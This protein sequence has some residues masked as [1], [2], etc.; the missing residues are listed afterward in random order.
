[1]GRVIKIKKGLTIPMNGMAER[2]MHKLPLPEFVAVKPTDFFG[3][4]PKLLVNEGDV[5]HAGQALVCDKINSKIVL[6]APASGVV[7]AIERGEKRKLEQ[8]VVKTD[9]EIHYKQFAVPELANATR[10]ELID[11]ML[12]SGAWLF[13]KERPYN[14][15]ANP[16]VQPKAV[17]ISTFNTAPLAADMSFVMADDIHDFQKGIDVLNILTNK[18]VHVNFYNEKRSINPF[19]KCS[20]FESHY[21]E[22]KHPAGNVGVQIHHIAP[23][24][25]GDVVWTM[26]PSDVAILGRLFSSGTFDVR[27]TIALTGEVHRPL[28]VKTILGA[29]I[30]SCFEGRTIEP[31]MRIISGDV[32]T[33]TNVGANGF[34]GFFDT[35][36]TVIPEV[37]EPEFMGWLAPGI[38]KFSASR[39][40]FSWLNV[41]KQ[42]TLNTAINGG[43]RAFVFTGIYEKVLPMNIYPMF[44]LKAILTNDIEKMEQLG[45]YEVVEEDFALCEYVC[46]SKI[47]IQSIIR[48]GLDMMKLA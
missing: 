2:I 17:Y 8:I 19:E 37:Q 11:L 22:G 42:Y 31:A 38:S 15:I 14:C 43:E 48:Q 9:A 26:Q 34:I 39:S 6:T 12:E 35:Q 30:P 10:E 1:M 4:T 13:I 40:F 28:Y 20:G 7:H 32:L 3:L 46:P 21:F 47:E 25:K 44:L 27:R 41:G 24:Q 16:A 18:A 23:I 45:I 5:V 36:I 33:G 29:H